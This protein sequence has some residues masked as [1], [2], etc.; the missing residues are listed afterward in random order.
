VVQ[1][2]QIVIGPREFEA[3][4]LIKLLESAKSRAGTKA[5][6]STLVKSLMIEVPELGALALLPALHGENWRKSDVPREAFSLLSRC[7]VKN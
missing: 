2:C 6:T 3:E 4:V 7:G 5:L 1:I